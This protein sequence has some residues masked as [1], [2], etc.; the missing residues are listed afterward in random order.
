MKDL[1]KNLFEAVAQNDTRAVKELLLN[2]ANANA[3]DHDDDYP[4]YHALMNEKDREISLALI[5]AMEPKSIQDFESYSLLVAQRANDSEIIDKLCDKGAIVNESGAMIWANTP[6]ML[7]QLIN[8]GG[9]VNHDLENKKA[10]FLSSVRNNE[11]DKVKVFVENGAKINEAGAIEWALARGHRDVADYLLEKTN[12]QVVNADE[13]ANYSSNDGHVDLLERFHKQGADL[14]K[15]ENYI[16]NRAAK[17]NH[18]DVVGYI[19]Q[20][21]DVS[22]QDQ[23][24]ALKSAIEHPEIVSLFIIKHKLKI[25]TETKDLIKESAPKDVRD[26]LVKVEMH[27]K[28]Q[29][30]LNT[31]KPTATKSKI[32]GYGM[33]I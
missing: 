3:K 18:I 30:N 28:L 11:L 24:T 23:E 33:K 4:L 2:G 16:L 25:S 31:P 32:K 29:N 1:D 20:H 15:D 10:P 12:G 26:I 8:R 19:L 21:T 6:E 7:Q 9:D 5:E 14:S 27:E 13:C 22:E 17:N